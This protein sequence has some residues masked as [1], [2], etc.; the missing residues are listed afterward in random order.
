LRKWAPIFVGLGLA[1]V[2]GWLAFRPVN[3]G[4]AA[5]AAASANWALLALAF[6]LLFLSIVFRAIRWRLILGQHPGARLAPLALAAGIGVGA[7]A[8]LPGKLGEAVGAHALG[9]LADLSRI[10]S[11]GILV[12]T[13]V[14]DLLVLFA[15]VLLASFVLPARETAAIQRFSIVMLVLTGLLVSAPLLLKLRVCRRLLERFRSV[16]ERVVGPGP[17]DFAAKFARGLGSAG[18]FRRLAAF[19]LSTALLW[20]VLSVSLLVALRAFH[21]GVPALLVPLVMALIAASAMLPSAPGNVGT[22]HYFGLLALGLVGVERGLAAACIITYHAMDMVSALALGAVCS[23]L[24]GGSVWRLR[25]A[26]EVLAQ[27]SR[28]AAEVLA[29]PGAFPAEPAPVRPHM[30]LATEET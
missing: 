10:Q 29:P 27:K 8:L 22:F 2:F 23:L 24:A 28:A 15:L 18:G 3:W 4:D 1:V 17:I 20:L 13:R 26:A 9:R 6:P 16:A 30:A 12:I 5:S 25:S 11:L 19:I 7:N 21:I 14:V